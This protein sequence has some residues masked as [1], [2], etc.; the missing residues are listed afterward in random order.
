MSEGTL[1]MDEQPP[2]RRMTLL[3]K[4]LANVDR[5]RIAAALSDR[6][7]SLRQIAREMGLPAAVVG[8]HLARLRAAGLL[9]EEHQNGAQ[10]YR[11]R[12]Q[13][14]MEALAEAGREPGPAAL[15]DDLEAH[16]R[17]VLRF[18]ARLF[19]PGRTYAEREV[20][21]ALSAYHDDYA[22]LRRALIDAG[23]L[24]RDHGLY[25]RVA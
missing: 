5:I 15:P 14:L 23:L 24:R 16:D 19:E 12:A 11:F 17:A 10:L 6:A 20:N 13:P 22:T 9:T 7:L 1:H 25:W 21:E 4:A 8:H 3:F 2:A 18:L